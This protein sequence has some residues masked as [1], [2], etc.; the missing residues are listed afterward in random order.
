MGVSLERL[1]LVNSIFQKNVTGTPEIAPVYAVF[2][3]VRPAGSPAF[4]QP[5][6]LLTSSHNYI[7]CFHSFHTLL[8]N[9]AHSF[10]L[11]T[12]WSAEALLPL[13]RCNPLH[14][15]FRSSYFPAARCHPEDIRQGCPKD[16]NFP[17]TSVPT[18]WATLRLNLRYNFPFLRSPYAHARRRLEHRLRIHPIRKP[19]QTHAH[20]R[21]LRSRLRSQA[22]RRRKHL[23]PHRAPPRF[24]LRALAQRRPRCRPR[25]SRRRRKNPPRARLLRRNHPRDPLSCGLLQRPAPVAA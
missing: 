5:L 15:N 11:G 16:L 6:V 3:P 18:C 1:F 13:L 14:P 17:F 21:N 12:F 24:R 7:L 25:A 2:S 23:G 10:H 4:Q 19:P 20:R 9:S 22:R 8:F